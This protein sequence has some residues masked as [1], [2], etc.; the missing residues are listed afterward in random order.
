MGHMIGTG[1]E[2]QGLYCLT[3]SNS[4]TACS[5]TDSSD[6]I[7][8]RLGH[9]SLSKLQKLVPSLSTLD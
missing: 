7:H 8:K 6:L 5:D 4:L 9:P 1:H 3:S 2:S